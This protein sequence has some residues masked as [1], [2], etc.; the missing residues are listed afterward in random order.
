MQPPGTKILLAAHVRM[1]TKELAHADKVVSLI[2]ID[3]K[4]FYYP[5]INKFLEDKEKFKEFFTIISYAKNDPPHNRWL[6]HPHDK[7]N[8]R[9]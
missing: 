9:E 1:L 2:S 5:S 7:D 6:H 3:K 8:F 4:H